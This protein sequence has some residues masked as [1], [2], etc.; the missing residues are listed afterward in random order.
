MKVQIPSSILETGLWTVIEIS[1]KQDETMAISA[2]LMDS[3]V[4]TVVFRFA[5]LPGGESVLRG[6]IPGA[7]FLQGVSTGAAHLSHGRLHAGRPLGRDHHMRPGRDAMVS[8][9]R[10]AQRDPLSHTSLPISPSGAQPRAGRALSQTLQAVQGQ[11]ETLPGVGQ[12]G[13]DTEAGLR[14]DVRDRRCHTRRRTTV[15]TVARQVSIIYATLSPA[16]LL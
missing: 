14:S 4:G 7:A 6:C 8:G 13:E 15:D 16:V 3:H 2:R 9:A 10:P 5:H 12:G 1:S 11:Q